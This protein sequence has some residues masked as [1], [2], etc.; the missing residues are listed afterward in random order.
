MADEKKPESSG[1]SGALPVTIVL[2]MLAGLV[3]TNLSPY[4]DERPSTHPLKEH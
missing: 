1:L 2:A 3:F 4:Q